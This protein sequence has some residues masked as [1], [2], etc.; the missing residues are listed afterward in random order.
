MTFRFLLY[1][2]IP[3][4][5]HRP[6]SARGKDAQGCQMALGLVQVI[7]ICQV[8]CMRSDSTKVGER[9]NSGLRESPDL[10]SDHIF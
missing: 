4:E 7:V 8:N 3:E 1:S 5:G 9:V 10:Y 6:H 2:A